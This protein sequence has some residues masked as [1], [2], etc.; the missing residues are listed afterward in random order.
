M[1]DSTVREIELKLHELT[2]ENAVLKTKVN[3]LEGAFNDMKEDIGK[4]GEK[5]D[6]TFKQLSGAYNKLVWFTMT[7]A[8]G[9]LGNI[10]LSLLT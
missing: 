2:T 10:A 3:N 6:E 1:S 7:S 8:V 5:I 4:L 9:M